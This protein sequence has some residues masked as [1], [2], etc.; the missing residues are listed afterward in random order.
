MLRKKLA[1]LCSGGGQPPWAGLSVKTASFFLRASLVLKYGNNNHNIFKTVGENN[2]K[3]FFYIK[4][5]NFK[6]HYLHSYFLSFFKVF[7]TPGI[8]LGGGVRRPHC[9]PL[10][11][12]LGPLANSVKIIPKW[13]NCIWIGY[14]NKNLVNN[15]IYVCQFLFLRLCTLVLYYICF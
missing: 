12:P 13:P 8:G 6:A 14:N 5:K 2:A 1:F 3:T 9:P 7:S 4:Q 11:T 15:W 10:A